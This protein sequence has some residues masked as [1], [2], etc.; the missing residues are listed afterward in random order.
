L[1]KLFNKL[2]LKL[3]FIVRFNSKQ[4]QAR[5]SLV[6][7]ETEGALV[8]PQCLRENPSFSDQ[9]IDAVVK[10][11]LKDGIS[12]VSSNSK[13]T[14]QINKKTVAVRFMEISILDA[15]RIFNER[16]PDPVGRSTFNSLHLRQLKIASPHETC[17]C[18]IHENMDLLL[19]VCVCYKLI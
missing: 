9:T 5:R 6:L 18:I 16:F 11:Y 19:K 4:N 17:M 14:I 2:S 1:H 12:R 7:R 13:D 15:F 8:Y 10:F 3:F